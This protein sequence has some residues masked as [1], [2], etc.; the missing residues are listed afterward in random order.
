MTTERVIDVLKRYN[1][2]DAD[3][4]SFTCEISE[5]QL[6]KL[7]E[8]IREQDLAK[9][10]VLISSQHG[11]KLSNDPEEIEAFLN[12]Y[13]SGAFTMIRVAKQAK[14]FLSEKQLQGIQTKL[15]L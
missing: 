9:G 11:Y 12:R 4:L 7:I 13:L 8:Q 6:R 2:C 5:R 3:T 1:Y 10:Y 15:E 14:M